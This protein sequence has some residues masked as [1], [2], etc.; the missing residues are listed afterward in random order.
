MKPVH[1]VAILHRDSSV[2]ARIGRLAKNAGLE[3]L[4]A[5]S[6]AEL[7]RLMGDPLV[8]AIVTA[9]P[10]AREG[11]MDA[12]ACLQQ[13]SSSAAVIVLADTEKTVEGARWAA[14]AKNL[15]FDIVSVQTISDDAFGRKLCSGREKAPE[16]GPADIDRCIDKKD[17]RVEYQPKV[18]LLSTSPS[19]QFGVEAL[20]RIRDPQFGAISPELFIPMA[21]KCGLIPK[22]TDAVI[23][24]A[25][26]DWHKW[27]AAGLYLRLAVNVSPLLLADNQWSDKFLTR[28]AQFAMDPKWITL[29]I[30]ESAAGAT[31][32]KAG[33]ILTR[34]Q[35]KGFA[36]SIDDFGTGFSSLSTLYRLPI[37]EMKIDKSF[38]LDLHKDGARSLVESAVGMAKRM[39]IK[40]VAEGVESESVFEELRAMGCHEV[41]GFFVG[42]SMP[43]DAV[44]PFFTG[45]R[46]TMHG[47]PAAQSQA[48]P[49]IAILQALLNDI[50]SDR[51]LEA[52]TVPSGPY[53][54]QAGRIIDPGSRIKE[55]LRQIPPLVLESK[56]IAALERCHEA[57]RQLLSLPG[58]DGIQ[59][60]I[61][62]LQTHLERTL[63]TESDLEFYTPHGM[64][65]LL[66][67]TSALFGRS[68]ANQAIDIPI[69][70]RWF[71]TGDKNLRIFANAGTWWVEDQGSAH[72]HLL[73]GQR[74][75]VRKPYELAF[76]RTQIQIRLTSGTGAPLSLIF[77][78]GPSNPDAV[79]F[80]FDFH[81]Q[82]LK[83]ELGDR[84]W[85]ELKG[86]LACTWVLFNGKIN[87]G[88]A[89]DCAV[90][91]DECSHP[92]A[93]S[94]WFD[95]GYWISPATGASLAMD[96]ISFK[97]SIPLAAKSE[98]NID[99]CRL[100][101][102]DIVRETPTVSAASASPY[103]TLRK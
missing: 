100:V 21:E 35:A 16:F 22:L 63:C 26:G 92:I 19:S 89:S 23:C 36:L 81:P 49:T 85:S 30:T 13:P 83:A 12:L 27:Q 101:V 11:G 5:A 39:G 4:C 66:P 32:P 38:I 96:D 58:C 90:V 25:F 94:L 46:K 28:C 56:N 88:R 55:V 10:S 98:L 67:R 86:E 99:G 74:M 77:Y 40:V 44:V 34:L 103:R 95:K 52:Q 102:Q 68:A 8:S 1:K 15:D 2:A 43:S 18:S 80:A 71:S 33:E 31:S 87:L 7:A 29:E 9:V 69:N 14:S 45:W 24:Q 62:Q 91:L 76:G 70:C 78:R 41:Q 61:A 3:I 65:R 47:A 60:K 97:Q 59:G 82:S 57:M 20:C 93:A 53:G 42:K 37:A 17:F 6:L 51:I 84:D 48:L 64:L 50:L 79:V 54:G 73:A 75:I 72:G